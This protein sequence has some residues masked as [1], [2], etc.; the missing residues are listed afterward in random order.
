MNEI[1][2]CNVIFKDDIRE[3]GS[4]PSSVNWIK[5]RDL[6]EIIKKQRILKST[7]YA[8]GEYINADKTYFKNKEPK[9]K[10]LTTHGD[11]MLVLTTLEK[12]DIVMEEY[13]SSKSSIFNRN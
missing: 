7:I 6:P 1:Y 3:E 12:I 5:D 8:W 10:I 9:I 11:T 2:F 13:L 4:E